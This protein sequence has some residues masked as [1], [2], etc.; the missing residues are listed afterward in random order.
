MGA[1]SDEQGERFHQVVIDFESS[2]Q[3]ECNENMNME[4]YI[5]GL[6][7]ENT[8]WF[9]MWCSLKIEKVRRVQKRSE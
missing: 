2:Y 8:Q 5:W 4:D 6:I 9:K 3:G 1:Y 7:R